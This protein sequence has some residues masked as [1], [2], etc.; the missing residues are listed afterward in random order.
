MSGQRGSCFWTGGATDN[1]WICRRASGG[2]LW[3][4]G[5]GRERDQLN[6]SGEQGNLEKGLSTKTGSSAGDILL[7]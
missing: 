7:Q 1:K 4:Q 6:R 2:G 5:G 3:E